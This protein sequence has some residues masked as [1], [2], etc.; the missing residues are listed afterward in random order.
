MQDPI[1]AGEVYRLDDFRERAGWGRAAM[2]AMRKRGLR[3]RRIGKYAYISAD[4]FIA[5]L[6]EQDRD[7]VVGPTN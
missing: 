2:R 7:S 1:K 3:V 4:D 5:L 6:D